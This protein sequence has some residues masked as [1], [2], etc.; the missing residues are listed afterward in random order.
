MSGLSNLKILSLLP[1]ALENDDFQ[2]SRRIYQSLW[3]KSKELGLLGE[4][5]NSRSGTIT[6]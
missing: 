5:A 1:T 6:I 2:G 3:G 4:M